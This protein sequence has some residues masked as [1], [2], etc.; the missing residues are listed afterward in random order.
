MP[1]KTKENKKTE[2][3]KEVKKTPSRKTEKAELTKAY[4]A[5]NFNLGAIRQKRRYK[6]IRDVSSDYYENP[7]D[8]KISEREEAVPLTYIELA[9]GA[10]AKT[11]DKYKHVLRVKIK[12][13]GQHPSY[14]PFAI[15]E[16]V[17]PS[18]P[19]D[20]PCYVMIP[21]N[22]FATYTDAELRTRKIS[23]KYNYLSKRIGAYTSIVPI[24]EPIELDGFT[25]FV[26]DR[27][28]AMEIQKNEWF[29][30]LEGKNGEKLGYKHNVGDKMQARVQAVTPSS[31]WVE[32]LGVECNIPAQELRNNFCTASELYKPGE[33]VWVKVTELTRDEEKWKVI[34]SLSVKQTRE[35]SNDKLWAIIQK[36]QVWDGTVTHVDGTKG[37]MFVDIGNDSR[38]WCHLLPGA[39][40]G[41]Q[42][43]VHMHEPWIGDDGEKKLS[44]YAEYKW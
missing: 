30:R 36:G 32:L 12:T 4:E 11:K 3:P 29:T 38:V 27:L 42:V 15:A 2:A 20:E 7:E 10:K 37:Y 39:K 18:A 1:A 22:R 24:K 44:G 13:V 6:A 16:Y 28:L 40:D 17:S 34:L 14:G 25:Y 21:Y 43:K 41:D 8:K 31:I 33:I 19:N 35:N 9:V 26:G 5:G 23:S